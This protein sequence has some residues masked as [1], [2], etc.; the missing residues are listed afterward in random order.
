M[1]WDILGSVDIYLRHKKAAINIDE[2]LRI[3]GQFIIYG[4]KMPEMFHFVK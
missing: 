3:D 1:F 4:R 2:A